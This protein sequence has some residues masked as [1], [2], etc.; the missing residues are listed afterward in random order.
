[1]KLSKK[2]QSDPAVS[3]TFN[4]VRFLIFFTIIIGIIGIIANFMMTKASAPIS[5]IV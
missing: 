2:A 5:P 3:E 4:W 1:M